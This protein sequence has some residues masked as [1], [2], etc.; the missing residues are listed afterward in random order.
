M[1]DPA[2][3]T[4]D[5]P[6]ADFACA[7]RIRSNTP[8]AALTVFN[9]P[10]FVEAARALGLRILREG[11]TSDQERADY[12]FQLCMLRPPTP[13][14]RAAVLDL[15]Q[16]RR[17]RIADG[18]LNVRDIVTGDPQRL[19]ELPAHATPQDA[20]AWTLAARVLLNLD[21]TVSKN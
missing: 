18:W 5:S 21:E 13:P 2:L 6:N 3:S 7:R 11:G 8:L 14:E 9:E 20:A 19:P 16:T 17:Q 4:L 10:I 1:P 12:A 15:L